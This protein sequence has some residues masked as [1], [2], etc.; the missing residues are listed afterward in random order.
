MAFYYVDH[1]EI[2]IGHLV[3]E[4]D[5]AKDHHK[6]LAL[7]TAIKVVRLSLHNIKQSQNKQK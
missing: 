5:R 1:F 3:T 4:R 2:V 6:R 7:S